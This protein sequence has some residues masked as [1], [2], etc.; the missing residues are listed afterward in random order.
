MTKIQHH[1]VTLCISLVFYKKYYTP[2]KMF[3]L[4]FSFVN[5][6][7]TRGSRGKANISFLYCP[8]KLLPN[9]QNLQMKKGGETLLGECI[10][11]GVDFQLIDCK[12]YGMVLY[13]W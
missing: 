6:E 8:K 10:V 3:L 4:A 11:C 7:T 12:W 2:K 5:F 9:F 13:H 1:K